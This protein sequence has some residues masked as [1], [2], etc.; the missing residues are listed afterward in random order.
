MG[1]KEILEDWYCDSCG[2][3]ITKD[4]FW[5]NE[6]G[7]LCNTCGAALDK[8]NSKETKKGESV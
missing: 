5:V 4:S 7:A 6:G 8:V 1:K 3:K 2:A